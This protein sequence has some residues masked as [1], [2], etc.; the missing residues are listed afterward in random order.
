MC[1][2]GERRGDA[3]ALRETA[4]AVWVVV[5]GAAAEVGAGCAVRELDAVY[6]HRPVRQ[7]RAAAVCHGFQAGQRQV[8]P[9][10]SAW[11]DPFH[12]FVV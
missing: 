9:R 4:V 2:A 1:A 5:R 8:L 10:L 3:V 11:R 7:A 12:V 6:L